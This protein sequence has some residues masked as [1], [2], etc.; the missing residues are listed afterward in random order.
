MGGVNAFLFITSDRT[1]PEKVLAYLAYESDVTAEPLGCDC[2]IRTF[3]AVSH[4]ERPSQDSFTRRRQLVRPDSHVGVA[5]S[6]D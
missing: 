1:L 4:R 3:S 6:D 5:A 2:L